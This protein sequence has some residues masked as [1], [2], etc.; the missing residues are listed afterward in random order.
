[1]NDIASDR[2]GP[3]HNPP[4]LGER[5]RESLDEVGWNVTEIATRL[6]CERETL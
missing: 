1:M 5:I 2:D 3:M 4:H 6:S